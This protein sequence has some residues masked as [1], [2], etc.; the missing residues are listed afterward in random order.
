MGKRKQREEK[1]GMALGFMGI[2][3]I[4]AGVLIIALPKEVTPMLL[5]FAG[6]FAVPGVL[7]CLIGNAVGK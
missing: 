2:V 4:A 5:G 7:L 3:L 6:C 1:Q